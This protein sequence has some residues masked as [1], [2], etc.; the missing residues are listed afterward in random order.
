[1]SIRRQEQVNQRWTSSKVILSENLNLKMRHLRMIDLRMIR[2]S[3]IL[4]SERRLRMIQFVHFL[5]AILL[6]KRWLRMIQFVHLVLKRLS[7][8]K[9]LKFHR[10]LI[11]FLELRCQAVHWTKE[12]EILI[13]TMKQTM[14][15]TIR[16]SFSEKMMI[17][18]RIDFCEQKH[19]VKTSTNQH[20]HMR[21]F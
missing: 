14:K 13:S 18:T 20:Q 17:E 15:K 1:M 6:S 7:Y 16:L 19:F 21:T 8:R 10:T 2:L 12:A 5:S 11:Q 4:L 9:V 3:A